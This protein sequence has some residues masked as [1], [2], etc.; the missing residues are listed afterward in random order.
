MNL[1]ITFGDT[2]EG[3]TGIDMSD[4]VSVIQNDHL[5]SSGGTK[6]TRFQPEEGTTDAM[7]KSNLIYF[8]F[9]ESFSA[10]VW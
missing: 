2:G 7:S 10:Y 1:Y 5:V 9:R 6:G 8:W 4:K 3:C